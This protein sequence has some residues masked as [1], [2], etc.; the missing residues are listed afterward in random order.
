[1][2]AEIDL[3]NVVA[4]VIAL[5]GVVCII[6]IEW[7]KAEMKHLK[8]EQ[9]KELLSKKSNPHPTTEYSLSALTGIIVEMQNMLEVH[10]GLIHQIVS[11]CSIA[12]N[13]PNLSEENRKLRDRLEKTMQ[14]LMLI[15]DDENRRRSAI[16]QLSQV[17][18]DHQSLDKMREVEPLFPDDENFKTGVQ[19]LSRR[20]PEPLIE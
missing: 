20:L 1:M 15:S 6:G 16:Q 11:T 13:M 7:V 8:Q 10:A 18:G 19:D 4:I 3:G 14:E 2:F 9:L 5:Q 17:F 12:D